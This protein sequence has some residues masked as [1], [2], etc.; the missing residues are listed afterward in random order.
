MYNSRHSSRIQPEPWVHAWVTAGRKSSSTV[1][2]VTMKHECKLGRGEKTQT[3]FKALKSQLVDGRPFYCSVWT[4]CE[5]SSLTEG[6]VAKGG[7]MLTFTIK[8]PHTGSECSKVLVLFT[9][10]HLYM[11]YV[12]HQYRLTSILVYRAALLWRHNRS[13]CK[14]IKT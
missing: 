2:F 7:R 6:G 4:V 8:S 5:S 3:G 11:L 12:A 1:L 10:F 9:K 14:K 13:S